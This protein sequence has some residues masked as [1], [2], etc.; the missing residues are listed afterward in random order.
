MTGLPWSFA[1]HASDIYLDPTGLPQK[2]RAARFVTTCTEESRRYLLGLVPDLDPTRIITVHH[3]LD[4]SRAAAV[5]RTPAGGAMLLAVGT[6][7]DCKGYDTLISAVARLRAGG[8]SADL[9]IVGDGEDRPQLE[10]QVRRLG[11]AERVTFTGYVAHEELARYYARAT[12]LVHP[13]RAAIHFGIPNVILEAQAARVPVVTTPLPALAEL[14]ED[15]VSLV[16]V[17][18]DDVEQLAATLR[19]V[20]AD[21]DRRRRLAEEGFRRVSERFDVNRTVGRLQSLFG[22]DEL[23]PVREAVG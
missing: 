20:L 16:H 10:A 11:L 12:L 7:R 3:G 9:T 6:L 19:G 13:A 5:E 8:V 2:L 15:G 14:G 23:P 17:P 22:V 1:G 18:E 21:A 4:L